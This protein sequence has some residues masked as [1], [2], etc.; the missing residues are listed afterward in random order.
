M[1]RKLTI[2]SMMLALS[3]LLHYIEGL[4]P[5]LIPLPGVKLGL[6]NAISLIVLYYFSR[7][8]Y[9]TIGVLRVLLVGL[10]STGLFSFGFFISVSGF[11]LSTVAVL[12]LSIWRKASIYTLSVTS[13]IFHVIGQVV[14]SAILYSQIGMMMY[15]PIVLVTGVI[16][17]FL[18][19]FVSSL[20]IK[21][22]D[23]VHF[24]PM[25]SLQTRKRNA[26][27]KNASNN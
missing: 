1:V 3:V 17:G 25:N 6:A 2:L 19:A 13:A 14:C 20:L 21:Q 11:V 22:L 12:L 10:I 4:I 8:E 18:I 7:K 23:K 9:I 27:S 15:L 24:N 5:P 16:A 26:S